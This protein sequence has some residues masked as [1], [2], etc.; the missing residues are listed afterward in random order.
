M[1]TKTTSW[2]A[3]TTGELE[4]RARDND[5]R[6]GFTYQ[7]AVENPAGGAFNVVAAVKVRNTSGGRWT[8]LGTLTAAATANFGVDDMA[9]NTPWLEHCVE[10]TTFTG[11]AGASATVVACTVVPGVTGA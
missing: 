10:F 9:T 5:S 8:T 11:G 7:L 6:Q 2:K 4:A 3:S 1:P